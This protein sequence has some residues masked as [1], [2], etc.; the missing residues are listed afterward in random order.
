MTAKEEI[1]ISLKKAFKYK[2]S[3]KLKYSKQEIFYRHL[4]NICHNLCALF[5]FRKHENTNFSITHV[6]KIPITSK[7]C[8]KLIFIIKSIC[9]E[10]NIKLSSVINDENHSRFC[11]I[12]DLYKIC[13][14]QNVI[15]HK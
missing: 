14:D 9:N 2:I 4:T 7:M 13:K 10:K 8:F 5:W 1:V 6:H 3:Y 15:S 11:S 12:N